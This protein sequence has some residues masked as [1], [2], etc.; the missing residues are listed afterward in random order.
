[1]SV[2]SLIRTFSG[3][4]RLRSTLRQQ[5]APVRSLLVALDGAAELRVTL[6][7]SVFGGDIFGVMSQQLLEALIVPPPSPPSVSK[8]HHKR[9]LPS[10]SDPFAQHPSN[11]WSL[12]VDRPRPSTL[13]GEPFTEASSPALSFLSSAP[14]VTEQGVTFSPAP[15]ASR[16]QSPFDK[17]ETPASSHREIEHLLPGSGTKQSP[18]TSALVSSLKRYWQAAREERNTNHAPQSPTLPTGSPNGAANIPVRDLAEPQTPR[19]WPTFAG[20]DLSAK[21]RSFASNP[22]QPTAAPLT[23]ARV[24]SDRQIQNVFNIEL[25]NANQ[26]APNYDDLGD[27]LAEILHEQALQHGIDVS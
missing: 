21:L 10:T 3:P 15:R 27:R 5:T 4:K 11:P 2:D 22:S 7:A 1:M 20:R 25:N 19:A 6:P 12:F 24:E 23:A 14:Q 26:H 9:S 17:A 18:A 8:P 16:I 13:P